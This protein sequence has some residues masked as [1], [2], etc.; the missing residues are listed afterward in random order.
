MCIEY[1]TQYYCKYHKRSKISPGHVQRICFGESVTY[2]INIYNVTLACY[3]KTEHWS[4]LK[5]YSPPTVITHF[6]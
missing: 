1:H 5:L 3:S 6:I 4:L 2:F